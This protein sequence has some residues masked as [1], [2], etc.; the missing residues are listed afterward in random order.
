M[1]RRCT[2]ELNILPWHGK[3]YSF[4][5]TSKSSTETRRQQLIDFASQTK[6]E[7]L[8]VDIEASIE[9]RYAYIQV[10]TSSIKFFAVYVF[11]EALL[12]TV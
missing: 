9:L 2:T 5:F 4:V 12:M 8:D 10:S 1:K 6:A 7:G 11:L 3:D